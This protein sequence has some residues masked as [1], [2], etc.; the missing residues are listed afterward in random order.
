MPLV[1]GDLSY[2]MEYSAVLMHSLFLN[3]KVDIGGK[4]GRKSPETSANGR[5]CRGRYNERQR[6]TKEHV[7]GVFK[8]EIKPSSLRGFHRQEFGLLEKCL[9]KNRRPLALCRVSC[10]LCCPG[11]EHDDTG[12]N[13]SPFSLRRLQVSYP[14]M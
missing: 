8:P 3:R 10:P 12:I 14:S 4:A 2:V 13:W 7:L 11:R 1:S 9:V 6:E 5:G